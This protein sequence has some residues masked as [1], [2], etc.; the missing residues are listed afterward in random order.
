MQR[1]FLFLFIV[2]VGVGVYFLITSDD[3]PQGTTPV[4]EPGNGS[5]ETTGG[6]L[7]GATGVGPDAVPEL[8]RLDR[9]SRALVIAKHAASWPALVISVLQQMRAVDYRSWYL[10]NA[11]TKE[12][13]PG[14]G[15]GMAALEAQPTGQ[16]LR[17]HDIEA[18]FLDSLDPNAL[19]DAFWDVVTERVENGRMGLYFRPSF[20]VGAGGAGVT[21]HPALSHPKLAALLPIARGALIQGTPLPG[22]YVEAQPLRVTA[23]GKRHPA[24]RLVNNELA[25]GKA[26]ASTAAGD[27]AFA[28]KFNYPVIDLA[29][30]A[31]SLVELEAATAVPAI[32]A[33]AAV[34]GKPRVIWMGNTDFGQR[35][36]HVRSKDGL[37]KLLVNHWV[38]WLVGQNEPR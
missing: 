33:T 34:A 32:V 13:G 9:P 1:I 15:R 14:D 36:Y 26:W 7:A 24:T 11:K 4:D 19:P 25:S 20:Y 8:R 2:A 29:P 21:Q 37:M 38:L 17:D 3:T 10:E 31:Q 23:Q 28:T 22:V 30:G 27:G 16:Y 35:A 12:A 18:L 6:G 5:G